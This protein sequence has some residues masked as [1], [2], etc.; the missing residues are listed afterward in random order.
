MLSA[1]FSLSIAHGPAMRKKWS[2]STFLIL[3]TN[4]KFIRKISAKIQN[5]NCW[6][7]HHLS[8]E[9]LLSS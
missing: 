3:G 5:N 1:I 2:E 6:Y 4:D 8:F 7:L 9:S